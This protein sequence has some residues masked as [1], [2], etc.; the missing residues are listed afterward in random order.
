[1]NPEFLGGPKESG[2]VT[3]AHIILNLVRT[4]R[5]HDILSNQ[6]IDIPEIFLEDGNRLLKESLKPVDK[7]ILI[8]IIYDLT[9]FIAENPEI[10]EEELLRTINTSLG[11]KPDLLRDD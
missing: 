8:D 3:V 4:H 11:I 1:M 9:I 6:Q 7:E 10:G 5:L 2:I